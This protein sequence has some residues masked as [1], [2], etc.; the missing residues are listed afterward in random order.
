M[1][2][3]GNLKCDCRVRYRRSTGCKTLLTPT[4]VVVDSV[5]CAVF[6]PIPQ[7]RAR[8]SFVIT[9]PLSREEKPLICRSS[10]DASQIESSGRASSPSPFSANDSMLTAAT[11]LVASSSSSQSSTGRW[12]A[13]REATATHRSVRRG[14]ARHIYSS[15]GAVLVTQGSQQCVTVTAERTCAERAAS[16]VSAKT[17][18]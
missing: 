8:I 6:S 5:W 9:G 1:F 18:E 16:S 7:R 14:A 4:C 3:V 15:S 13:R 10:S 11:S 12:R 2:S 17:E